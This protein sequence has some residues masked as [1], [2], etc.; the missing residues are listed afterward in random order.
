MAARKEKADKREGTAPAD[1]QEE[2]AVPMGEAVKEEAV[3]ETD[4]VFRSNC[5]CTLADLRVHICRPGDAIPK[6]KREFARLA[7]VE[8]FQA[9]TLRREEAG[10]VPIA[11]GD[12]ANALKQLRHLNAVGA[13]ALL[14]DD[15]PRVAAFNAILQKLIQSPAEAEKK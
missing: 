8:A 13:A 12:D 6:D 2:K 15:E 4:L 5:Y 7:I 1:V 3:P 11:A 9:I 10:L 14:A